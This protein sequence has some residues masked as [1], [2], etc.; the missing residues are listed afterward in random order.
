MLS[1]ARPILQIKLNEILYD[2]LYQAIITSYTSSK[3]SNSEKMNEY[4]MEANKQYAH[5]MAT[6]FAQ[7]ASGELADAIYE[8]VKSIGI[9]LTPAGGLQTTVGPVMGVATTPIDF[10]IE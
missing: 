10:S 7:M 8:F 6:K 3:E 9:T 1:N 5:N 2:S 4:A